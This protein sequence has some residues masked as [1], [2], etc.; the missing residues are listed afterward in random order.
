MKR[1]E[2]TAATG[3]QRRSSAGG[4][5]RAL[6]GVSDRHQRGTISPSRIR[7]PTPPARI[8]NLALPLDS[9]PPLATNV[10]VSLRLSS[11]S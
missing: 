1:F 7:R 9:R 5:A 3:L 2:G 8:C 6:R 10:G 11:F 4:V